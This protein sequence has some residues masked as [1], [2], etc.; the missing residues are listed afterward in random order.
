MRR[1]RETAAAVSNETAVAEVQLA[2]DEC[3][4]ATS[5]EFDHRINADA[6]AVAVAC[7]ALQHV[8][9]RHM[10]L[11]RTAHE[12]KAKPTATGA[13]QFREEMAALDTAC[14]SALGAAASAI[15]ARKDANAQLVEQQKRVARMRQ[16][17]RRW[18]GEAQLDAS[19]SRSTAHL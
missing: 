2:I 19:S 16:Y 1:D 12:L 18:T 4:G 13:T 6:P 11:I 5:N 15:Q 10:E 9:R 3:Y 8:R 14:E 7:D 17:Y